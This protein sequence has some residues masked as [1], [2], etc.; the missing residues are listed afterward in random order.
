VDSKEHPTTLRPGTAYE[1]I[2]VTTLADGRPLV[3]PVHRL[4]GRAGGPRLGLVALLH[5]DEPLPNEIIRRVLVTV[6]SDSLNGEI[7]ALPATH[8]P[9]LEALSR[10]SPIDM[11]DLNRNF[12]G[13]PRGW[14]TEQLAHAISERLL[15]D[16]D[17]LIDL[18]SGGLFP[19][20]DYVYAT[21]GAVEIALALGCELNYLTDNPHPGGLLGVARAHGIPSAILEI[22]GGQ[23]DDEAFI[24]RGVTAILNVLK[25]FKMIEGPPER[26]EQQLAFTEMETLRPRRGGMLYPQVG[27]RRLGGLV[28]ESELLGRVVSALTFETLEE[29]R[30]PFEGYLL[31]LR[32][33]LSPVNPGDF[34]Y[35]VA[36]KRST[37]V[38]N[39]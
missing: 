22:G 20:V 29:L 25:H 2:E 1:P 13:D 39:P 33:A 17:L 30:S 5:G 37:E 28:D 7:L 4:Q 32:A 9:A 8:G 24:A 35:M 31:L 36:D 10:N 18:H 15:S 26:A 16:I 14:L 6:A 23:Q 38:V 19:T 27:L 11:L 34:A 21:N 12:P 3:I